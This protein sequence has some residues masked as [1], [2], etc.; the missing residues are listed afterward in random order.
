M[1]Y[2]GH[3]RIPTG[4]V[5]AGRSF[6]LAGTVKPGLARPLVI[7]LPG[8]RWTTAYAQSQTSATSYADAHNFTLVY[9]QGAREAWNAGGCCGNSN[10][11]DDQYLADV[12]ASVS[13]LT[14]VDRGR[15]YLMGFSNGGMMA[16]KAA[17]DR[18]DLFAA[19][20][21]VSGPLLTKCL[22]VVHFIHLHGDADVDVPLLGGYS[23]YTQTF[24][25]SSMTESSRLPSG[26]TVVLKVIRRLDH[27]WPTVGDSGINGI[28]TLWETVISYRLRG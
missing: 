11:N 25:P 21:S 3:Y 23:A 14:P 2:T 5:S 10:A 20:G 18:P 13:R 19:A 17:C 4:Y 28:A 1:A 22:H 16:L 26:S 15:V 24:F 9:A 6:Y 12:V 27:R 7:F 8:W